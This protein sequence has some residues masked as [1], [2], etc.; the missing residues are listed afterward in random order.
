MEVDE[1]PLFKSRSKLLRFLWLAHIPLVWQ[2]VGDATQEL[3]V[4]APEE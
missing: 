4:F 3:A 1:V 2:G